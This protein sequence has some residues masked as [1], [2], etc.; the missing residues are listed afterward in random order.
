LSPKKKDKKEKRKT[1]V[2]VGPQNV[3][4]FSSKPK[5]M[6]RLPSTFYIGM[7]MKPCQL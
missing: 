3:L 1:V 2:L 5:R 4:S 6:K 7:E